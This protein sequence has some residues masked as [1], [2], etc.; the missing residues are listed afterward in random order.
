MALLP[1]ARAA[2]PR[3]S[4]GVTV[5]RRRLID[6]VKIEDAPD[7]H[8]YLLS[9]A[10]LR[11]QQ[12]RQDQG[13]DLG[14]VLAV[15]A[16]A[17]EGEVLSRLPFDRIVLSGIKEP[18]A[19]ITQLVHSSPGLDYRF[20]NGE[21]LN[22]P[23][24][25]FD[26]VIFKETLHHFARPVAGLYEG[27]RVC[28]AAVIIIEPYDSLLGRVLVKLG[29]ASEFERD[30]GMNVEQR[31]NYVFRWDAHHLEALL[32]SYYLDSG[33]SLDISLGWMTWKYTASSSRL[34][35]SLTAVSGCLAS[36]VPG[37]GG[38]Y[39]SA[40]I[41]PGTLVPCDPLSAQHPKGSSALLP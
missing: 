2:A 10:L 11:Y 13:L 22:L 23:S 17:Y 39:M 3:A 28:R 19:K 18:G 14:E 9:E 27:L 16:S 1:L 34:V 32:K 20:E 33:F 8:H 30:E 7:F 41:M 35:R 24:R 25:S 5:R 31:K 40:L 6:L 21:A 4:G 12:L 38:N 36:L 29:I 37:A 26:L 15:G